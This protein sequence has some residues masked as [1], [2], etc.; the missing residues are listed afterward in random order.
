MYLNQVKMVNSFKIYI[1]TAYKILKTNRHS[2]LY[3]VVPMQEQTG[4]RHRFKLAPSLEGH[5]EAPG[6][7]MTIN[8]FIIMARKML[9]VV[10]F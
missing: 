9:L 10:H 5:T 2:L 7:C 4:E 3:L 6:G 8:G 1:F